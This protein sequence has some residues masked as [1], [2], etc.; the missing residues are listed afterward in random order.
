MFRA[1]FLLLLFIPALGSAIELKVATAANFYSTLNKI[2]LEYEKNTQHSITII[3]GSTGKLYAQIINGAPFDIFFSADSKRVDRLVRKNKTVDGE[4]TIYAVGQLA[5]WR[6]DI[7]SSQELRQRL[8][9]G[10]FKKLAIANP[11]TAPYGRAS[12]Q[13]LKSMELYQSVK[14]KLVY[15][16]NI[17]Q[18]LQFVQSGAADMGLVARPHVIHDIYWEVE[19]YLHKPIKQKMVIL[20][21]SK[22]VEIAKDFLASIKSK[23]IQKLIREEGYFV[24]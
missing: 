18:A 16:E 20:K 2:K 1:I 24:D 4:A 8:M 12:V 3:R 6:P 15:G 7:N 10:D 17:S 11:K 19:T 9:S 22:Q 5:L 13:T 21:Q 23:E 14:N